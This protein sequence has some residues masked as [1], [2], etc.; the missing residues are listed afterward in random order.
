MHGCISY[1]IKNG[2][3]W[4]IMFRTGWE[5]VIFRLCCCCG[6]SHSIWFGALLCWKGSNTGS[7]LH[8][9][10]NR[11]YR[12][13]N[14]RAISKK[15]IFYRSS[16]IWIMM[17]NTNN[18]LKMAKNGLKLLKVWNRNSLNH[19]SNSAKVN[20]IYKCSSINILKIKQVK[21]QRIQTNLKK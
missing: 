18:L 11:L 12:N 9:I 13:I 17:S 10:F 6:R 8:N 20:Y 3:M 16:K 14:G 4:P 15:Y 2:T 7:I 1:F 21:I 19:K 5:I